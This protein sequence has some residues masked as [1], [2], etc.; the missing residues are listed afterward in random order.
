MLGEGLRSISLPPFYVF[1]KWGIEQHP[2]REGWGWG[3]TLKTKSPVRRGGD[4][5][6][7]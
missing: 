4:T 3:H 7:G 1:S 2:V 6:T 5:L